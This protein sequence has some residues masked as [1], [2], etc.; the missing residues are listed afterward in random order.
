MRVHFEESFKE[1]KNGKSSHMLRI[2]KLFFF[3]EFQKLKS[4]TRIK[5]IRLRVAD[6]LS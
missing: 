2:Q 5:H 3:T 6:K 1:I 4:Q